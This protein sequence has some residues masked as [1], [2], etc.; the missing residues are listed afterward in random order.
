MANSFND[1]TQI[2]FI[3]DTFTPQS[4]TADGNGIGVDV[5]SVGTNLL[6]A[7]LAVGDV[8]VFTSLAVKMQASTDNTTFVDITGATF[9]T[10]TAANGLE[11]ISFQLPI[12]VSATTDPYKYVRAVADITGTS[13]RIHCMIIACKREPNPTLGYV[14]GPMTIN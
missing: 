14:S 10:V 4:L 7:I 13:A 12:A 2:S 9:T 6:N 11:M 8:T 5:S 1:L 3:A